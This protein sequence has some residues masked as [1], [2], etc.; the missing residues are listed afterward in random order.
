MAT[1]RSWVIR[2]SSRRWR[3]R[4][5]PR[6][7][8]TMRW[9][10]R[11]RPPQPGCCN[12]RTGAAWPPASARSR[13]VG[14]QALVRST[15]RA[16]GPRTYAG[17]AAGRASCAAGPRMTAGR[18]C[19][20]YVWRRGAKDV[21]GSGVRLVRFAPRGQGRTQV[22]RPVGTFRARGPRTI[23]GR[24]CG[25]YV[26]RRGARDV[27]RCCGRSGR[28]APAGQG[29]SWV[30]PAAR[31]FRAVGP[32]TYAG[33]AAGRDVSRRGA[34]DDRGSRC[35]SRT[36]TAQHSLGRPALAQPST[37]RSASAWRAGLTSSGW[38]FGIEA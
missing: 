11:S 15:F 33:A 7:R 9:L 14:Q 22:L 10:P 36:F 32:G 29:R 31:T 6:R 21:R 37:R 35:A 20:T 5:S 12:S 30:G 3:T 23:A 18:A 27:R 25:S 2:A 24:A 26:S 8:R 38:V 34:K 16:A 13:G 28:F 17:A 4:W 1:S 19:G